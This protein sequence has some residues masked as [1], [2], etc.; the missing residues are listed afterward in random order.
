MRG[1]STLDVGCGRGSWLVDFVQW[2]VDPRR[3]AGIDIVP[4]RVTDA[5]RS[6]PDAD[7]QVGDAS[8]MPWADGTFDVVSQFGAFTSVLDSSMRRRMAAEMLRVLKPQGIILW[9]DFAFNNPRN[10]NVRGIKIQD[11]RDLFAGC[12]VTTRK[13]M[14]APPLARAVVPVSWIFAQMLE[15]LPFLRTH[16]IGTIRKRPK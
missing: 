5:R 13:I 14:L 7:I 3:V 16:L 2:G 11:I 12:D 1:F 4:G 6:L 8:R 15:K 9:Y 10:P